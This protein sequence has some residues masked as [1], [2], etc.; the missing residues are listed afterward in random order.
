MVL[1]PSKMLPPK[2]SCLSPAPPELSCLQRPFQMLSHSPV[3]VLV[4]L[5]PQLTPPSLPVLLEDVCVVKCGM[6]QC[7]YN[8]YI[9]IYIYL[10]IY[11]SISL[12]NQTPA[13]S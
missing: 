7:T 1:I 5:V 8:Q 12:T 2:R 13:K 4:L 10:Y 9:Y 3:M 6:P 11:Q